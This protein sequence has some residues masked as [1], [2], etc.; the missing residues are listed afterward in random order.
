MTD[1][2][3]GLFCQFSMHIEKKNKIEEINLIAKMKFILSSVKETD[4][5]PNHGKSV[6]STISY[7]GFDDIQR[8]S[9][10]LVEN[11]T[12]VQTKYSKVSET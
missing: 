8:T 3:N 11:L 4:Q 6:A 12:Q 2:D 1:P 9:L 5:T 10:N 7:F